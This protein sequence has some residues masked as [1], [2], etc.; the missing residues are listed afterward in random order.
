MSALRALTKII[1]RYQEVI[2]S[3]GAPPTMKIIPEIK[4]QRALWVLG[5]SVPFGY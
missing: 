4:R 1:V 5:D 2:T 3:L